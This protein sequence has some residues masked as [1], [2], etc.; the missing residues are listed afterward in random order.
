VRAIAVTALA[1]PQDSARAL[2]AGFDGHLAKPVDP[3]RLVQL[4]HRLAAAARGAATDRPA[5]A[6]DDLVAR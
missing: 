5:A 3:T 6:P 2:A 4:L 1:R